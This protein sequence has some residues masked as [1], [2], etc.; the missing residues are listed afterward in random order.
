LHSVIPRQEYSDR[1][2]S[3]SIFGRQSEL[4]TALKFQPKMTA[5]RL[6]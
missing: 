5:K 6:N 2:G 1:L 3:C 4:Q